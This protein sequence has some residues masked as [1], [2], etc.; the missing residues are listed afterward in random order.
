[1]ELKISSTNEHGRPP[2]P[3]N[4]GVFIRDYRLGGREICFQMGELLLRI[5]PYNPDQ[6][7]EFGE[8]LIKF[9]NKPLDVT[10]KSS[11]K[12]D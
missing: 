4:F 12:S 6:I 10:A 8:K 2:L 11:G 9:T 3:C 7:K 1:M 5:Y